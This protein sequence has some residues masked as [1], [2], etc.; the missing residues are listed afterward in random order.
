[1]FAVKVSLGAALFIGMALLAMRL[2]RDPGW[3]VPPVRGASAGAL[4]AAAPR[5]AWAAVARRSSFFTL[6]LVNLTL[7]TAIVVTVVVLGY[8]HLLLHLG[9]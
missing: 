8:L 9:L 3:L 1:M 6:A 4:A 7:A 2:R 5:S